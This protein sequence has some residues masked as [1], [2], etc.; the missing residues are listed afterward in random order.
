MACGSLHP[1]ML[2]HLAFVPVGCDV[3]CQDRRN[4]CPCDR[5]ISSAARDLAITLVDWAPM[6]PDKEMGIW[7][8]VHV[9]ATGP[10]VLRS[11]AVL[12][13]LKLPATNEASLIVRAELTNTSKTKIDAVVKGRIENLNFQQSV[14][15]APTETKVVR[16]TPEK[17]AQRKFPIHVYGGRHEHLSQQ[18]IRRSLCKN[19]I[20]HRIRAPRIRIA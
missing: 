12:T 19:S 1:T 14:H 4:E 20:R 13:K 2:L 10:I 15:L 17:F 11:P 6:P 8:D 16:F 18:Y 3:C 9:F 7:R 5:G